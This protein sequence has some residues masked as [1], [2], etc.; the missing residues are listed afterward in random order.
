MDPVT[1]LTTIGSTISSAVAPAAT[2]ATTAATSAP[3]LTT[4]LG[5]AATALSV[6]SGIVRSNAEAKALKAQ[7]ANEQERARIEAENAD[8]RAKEEV[9]TAQRRAGVRRREARLAKSRLIAEAGGS[10]GSTSDPTVLD[11]WGDIDAEGEI[12]AGQETAFGEQ[13]ARGIKFQSDL[14]SFTADRNAAIKRAS[15]RSTQIGG[16]TTGLG[17]GLSMISRYGGYKSGSRRV[18]G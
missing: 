16:L 15:A 1:L 12:N 3:G 10:G 5:G 13:R 14:N 11:L 17:K 18:Y 6:G 7:A 9:A 8:V 2:A 4:L